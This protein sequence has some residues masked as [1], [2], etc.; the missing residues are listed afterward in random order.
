MGRSLSAIL[1]LLHRTPTQLPAVWT[2][3]CVRLWTQHTSNNIIMCGRNP[4]LCF[5]SVRCTHLTIYMC[6]LN[7]FL[8]NAVTHPATQMCRVIWTLSYVFAVNAAHTSKVSM[9]RTLKDDSV[10]FNSGWHQS[11]RENSHTLFPFSRKFPQCY[12]WKRLF[13]YFSIALCCIEDYKYN[14][15]IYNLWL[16]HQG[17]H[18]SVQENPHVFPPFLPEV[19]LTLPLK[20]AV[21]CLLHQRPCL[22]SSRSAVVDLSCG[23]ETSLLIVNKTN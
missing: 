6:G 11:I 22:V 14:L 8:C 10:Q 3:F 16:Y 13:V 19:S 1:S 5:C 9:V 12:L 4:I 18:L 15:C 21:V 20:K 23:P 17:Q 7:A 2:L